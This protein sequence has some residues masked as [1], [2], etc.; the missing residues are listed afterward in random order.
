MTVYV[1]TSVILSYF[2]RNAIFIEILEVFYALRHLT[3]PKSK[4]FLLKKF[5]KFVDSIFPVE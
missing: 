4:E 3:T 1:A 5:H 2:S